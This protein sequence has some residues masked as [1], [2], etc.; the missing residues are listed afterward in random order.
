QARK[1]IEYAARRKA[2]I[3]FIKTSRFFIYTYY[4]LRHRQMQK[5]PLFFFEKFEPLT[6][7][8]F[9]AKLNMAGAM[10]VWSGV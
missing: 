3:F 4:I 5:L 10:C 9:K 6:A 7:S 1:I 2:K 8:G